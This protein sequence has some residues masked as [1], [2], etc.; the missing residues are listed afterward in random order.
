VLGDRQQV[1]LGAIDGDGVAA[2]VASTVVSTAAGH[3]VLDAGAKALTKDLPSFVEGYGAIPAWP[4][5]IVERLYDYH[6]VV[7]LPG[8]A[9]P[10]PLGSVVAV[11]PNHICPVVDLMSTF[12]AV[13]ADGRV[14][15]WAVDARGRSG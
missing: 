3:A 15:H 9:A 2:V 12:A 1:G 13:Q 4:G 7:S 14:E 5:A 11:V 6:G 10:P 8:P